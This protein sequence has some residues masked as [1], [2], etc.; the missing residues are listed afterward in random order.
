MEPQVLDDVPG[1]RH[2][3]A[4]RAEGL[5]EG[6][7]HDVHVGRVDAELLAHAPPCP[8]QRADAVRLV[9]VEVRLVALLDG[10]DVDEVAHLP[11]H[12]VDA[13]HHD[14]DLP[15]RAVRPGLPLRDGVPQHALEVPRVV[16]PEDPDLGARA[17]HPADDGGVVQGIADDKVSGAHQRRQDHA[18]GR[19]A[20]PK[21]DRVLLPKEARDVPLELHVLGAGSAHRPGAARAPAVLSE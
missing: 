14:E 10:D 2:V 12:A 16:V 8:A 3:A 5:G 7:H 1:S 4:A 6:S 18:V 11:L 19:K 21:H 9:Q 15:P 17:P 20:H 13:L